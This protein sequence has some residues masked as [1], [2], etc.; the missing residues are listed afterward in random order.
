MKFMKILLREGRKED[1]KK[2]YSDKF[3]E[4]TL[5]WIL[6]ISDLV[7][8]NHKY[9]DF[10]LKNI[11]PKSQDVEWWVEE[12]IGL[13]KLFDKYQNQLEKKDINQY[14][15]YHQLDSVISPIQQREKE[16][17]LEKRADKIYEDNRILVIKPKTK[18]SSCKYGKGTRWC[19]AATEGNRFE[20]YSSGNQGLYYI[21]LKGLEKQLGYKI[22]V[23]FA[24]SGKM[25]L[26]D[27]EDHMLSDRETSLIMTQNR[28]L[29]NTILEDYKNSRVK[30]FEKV[31]TDAFD[32]TKDNYGNVGVRND[33]FSP[34]RVYVVLSGMNLLPDM[35]NH[36]DA[37]IQISWTYDR[38]TLDNSELIDEY[39]VFINYRVEGDILFLD[40][41]LGGESDMIKKD[42]GLSG[43]EMRGVLGYESE[44]SKLRMRISQ[45]I[46]NKVYE[47]LLPP[48][49]ALSDFLQERTA[50]DPQ[51]WYYD[52]F[53]GYKFSENKGLIKSLVD[54]LDSGKTGT[55]LDFLT[56]IGKMKR[57]IVNNRAVYARKNSDEYLPSSN[58]RGQL[59]SF[60]STAKRAGIIN[61]RK[62][63]NQFYIV[64]GPN[65][66]AFKQGNLKA[67]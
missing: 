8:F 18:Q 45:L 54:W 19:T 64:K 28:E 1:L 29:F 55:K 43:I 42:L 27:D 34:L 30:G 9:T 2:K 20:E 48:N 63:S 37:T 59:A 60:F 23:H 21:I 24:N 51:T 61:Y 46:I 11:D 35:G 13:I 14:E 16:K 10:V 62:V 4:K 57:K 25:S 53:S 38:Y 15:N 50:N 12:M 56:D 40:F 3:D 58:W 5:D 6:G 52:R 41:S 7:D 49:T 17:E 47:R 65:F 31:V 39:I 32:I 67:I 33:T 22:A 26:W 36:A 44:S 66:E